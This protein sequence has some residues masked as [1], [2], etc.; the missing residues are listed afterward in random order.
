MNIS[1]YR[2][3]CVILDSCTSEEYINQ[4]FKPVFGTN[5]SAFCQCSVRRMNHDGSI[6]YYWVRQHCP[7][8]LQFNSTINV[9]DW[10]WNVPCNGETQLSAVFKHCILLTKLLNG[11]AVNENNWLFFKLLNRLVWIH[12]IVNNILLL[13]N[14]L[15]SCVF[16]FA[17]N[18][19]DQFNVSVIYVKFSVFKSYL[20]MKTNTLNVSVTISVSIRI[21]VYLLK[22]LS[23]FAESGTLLF[24]SLSVP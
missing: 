4:V 17:Q 5:C 14:C 3:C 10:S 7:S 6:D 8:G 21:I 19:V 18:V 15:A 11:Y 20:T 13:L 16:I 2:Q 9:C 22:F 1:E 12:F 24:L 23:V